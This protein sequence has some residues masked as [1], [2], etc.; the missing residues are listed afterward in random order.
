MRLNIHSIFNRWRLVFLCAMVLAT[1][2]ILSQPSVRKN[3]ATL[4]YYQT[5]SWGIRLETVKVGGNTVIPLQNI[6]ETLSLPKGY[7]MLAIN[8][9]DLRQKLERQGWIKSA[10]VTKS[11]PNTLVIQITEHTP[12]ALWQNNKKYQLIS[13]NGDLMGQ[14][15]MNQFLDLLLLVGNNIPK[16]TQ[17]ISHMLDNMPLIKNRIKIVS[18][19]SDRW[20]ALKT[21]SDIEILLPIENAPQHASFL[22]TIQ[23]EKQIL[24]RDIIRIDLRIPDRMVIKLRTESTDDNSQSSPSKPKKKQPA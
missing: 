7:P 20:W 18:L 13:K 14:S 12:M 19:M 5:Q 3:L 16:R 10:I 23:Q 2:I 15:H 1:G 17:D 9:N 24:D 11:L 8:T 4:F 21:K 6:M 22:N